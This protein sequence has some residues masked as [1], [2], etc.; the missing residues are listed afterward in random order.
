MISNVIDKS[1]HFGQQNFMFCDTVSDTNYDYN[2]FMDKIGLIFVS[3]FKKDGTE[4]R[5]A[6]SNGD[7]ATVL[8]G[9][10]IL[11]YVLPNQLKDLRIQVTS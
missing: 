9:V 10:T 3:R 8:S 6:V 7:Y 2:L 11:T 4:G 5:Y 1:L